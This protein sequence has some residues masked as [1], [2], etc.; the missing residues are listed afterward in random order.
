MQTAGYEYNGNELLSVIVRPS[1]KKTLPAGLRVIYTDGAG[2][3]KYTFMSQGGHNLVKY[4]DGFQGGVASLKKQKKFELAEFKSENQWSKQDYLDIIQ[5]QA[6][7]LKNAFQNDIFKQE[8]MTSLPVP[9]SNLVDTLQTEE[10]KMIVIAEWMMQQDGINIGIFNIFWLANKYKLTFDA[11]TFPNKVVYSKYA[12]DIR[13]SGIDGVWTNIERDASTTPTAEQI[14]RV[15]VSAGADAQVESITLAGT[16]GSGNITIKGHTKLATFNT[17]LTTTAADFVAANKTYYANYG[18]DITS[19]LAVITATSLTEGVSFDAPT[20]ANVSGNL[21]AVIANVTANTVASDLTTDQAK[22]IFRDMIKGQ[23]KVLK[24]MEKSKKVFYATQSVIDNYYDTMG[25]SGVNMSTSES[26]RGVMVNGLEALSF[27]GIPIELMPIDTAIDSDFGG[28]A[29][30]RVILTTKDNICLIL[31]SAGK[32]GES[33]LWYNKDENQNR[34][35][36]QLE[37]GG[38]YW[39]PEMLV[40]AY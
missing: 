23:S 21:A 40:A 8:I 16:G 25:A 1:I 37:L 29:P 34:T 15:V 2:T 35:R 32:L 19:A 3:V 11:G 33:M 20:F 24:S 13:Y 10:E 6:D 5:R 17:N 18:I 28:Y 9:I 27:N 4:A 30:H 7:D 26:A 12:E 38:D 39:L 31:S 22:N 14:K 36:T